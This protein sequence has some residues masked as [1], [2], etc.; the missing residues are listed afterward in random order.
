MSDEERDFYSGFIRLHILHH[1]SE[2]EIFGASIMEELARHGYRLSPGT[3]YPVLHAMERK[4]L[5]SSK[6]R[7]DGRQ[8]RRF[9]R[10]TPKGRRALQAAKHKI[11]ELFG[12]LLEHD[13]HEH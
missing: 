11:Q 6:E 7:K 2:E 3:L 1:A 8:I 4:G 10:A 12:E 5:L 13:H 9:Y